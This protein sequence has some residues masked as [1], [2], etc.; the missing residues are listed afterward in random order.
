MTENEKQEQTEE[1][2]LGKCIQCGNFKEV[3]VVDSALSWEQNVEIPVTICRKCELK[4]I[5]NH[6]Y[7]CG[8][9]DNC[10]HFSQKEY[11]DAILEKYELEQVSTIQGQIGVNS[12]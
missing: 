6:V 8:G 3:K 2:N 12:K 9:I 7:S 11:K 5:I 10:S 4:S 1:S